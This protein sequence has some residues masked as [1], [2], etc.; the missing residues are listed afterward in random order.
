[1]AAVS[2][3]RSIFREPSS[4]TFANL[5][6]RSSIRKTMKTILN[7]VVV[8]CLLIA[9]LLAGSS[10]WMT[11][12][13]LDH[14]LKQPTASLSQSLPSLSLPQATEQNQRA[15]VAAKPS[16]D[17]LSAPLA[18][19]SSDSGYTLAGVPAS[20][21]SSG[22]S[23]RSA[24]VV[25][26]RSGVAHSAGGSS[27]DSTSSGAQAI[28]GSVASAGS[29]SSAVSYHGGV[30]VSI[31]AGVSVPVAFNNPSALGKSVSPDQ[32]QAIAQIANEFTTA[33]QSSGAA[34][35]TPE[36]KQAW[37][38]AAYEADERFRG[39]FG[40]PAFNAMQMARGY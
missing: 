4:L 36:Y 7:P 32:Q 31:P 35:D 39:T 26:T 18:P 17:Q 20:P 34:S 10:L 37:D 11:W 2:S 6:N 9:L 22:T 29:G 23:F 19:S 5:Q 15:D 38:T 21:A 28:S 14:E 13:Q 12:H 24:S 8:I 33:V 16:S 3:A 40:I 1:M 27:S 30:S 25:S